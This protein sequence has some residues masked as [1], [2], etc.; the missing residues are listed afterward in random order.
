MDPRESFWGMVVHYFNDITHFDGKF[1]HTAGNLLVKPGFLPLEYIRGR[2]A[3]YLHPIR[4]YIFTSAVFFLAFYS[5]SLDASIRTNDS[6]GDDAK[7][8]FG[9]TLDTDAEKA[10]KDSLLTKYNSVDE[11]ESRQATLPASEKDGWLKHRVVTTFIKRSDKYGGNVNEV[12]NSMKDR[13]VH[14]FPTLLFILL[15]TSAL[16]LQLL[17]FKNEKNVYAGHIIFLIYLYVF[18]FVITLLFLGLNVLSVN[19]GMKW[20]RFIQYAMF[21]Y[22]VL[23]SLRAFKNYYAEGWSRTIFKFMVL[24]LLVF[25][26]TIALFVFFILI[27]LIRV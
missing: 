1:F 20:L 3:R 15:P 14:S 23:Y 12:L 11:Y 21:V 4:L 10:L 9:I 27:T 25:T 22:I 13:F 5:L 17:Y 16:F 2:R 19:Y 6:A 24:N 26:S 18:T 7:T 8:N